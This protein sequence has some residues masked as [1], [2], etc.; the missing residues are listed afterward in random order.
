MSP[1][2]DYRVSPPD[3]RHA[4]RRRVTLEELRLRRR[5]IVSIG[6]RHGVNN[7]RVFGS[8]ARGDSE[9]GS[10]L[11]LLVD[12]T[13]GSSLWDLTDFALDVEEMLGVFTQVVTVSGLKARI[14]DHVLAE[15]VPL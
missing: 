8:V 6:D 1:T 15:A 9:D 12:V 7:V 3:E 4:P 11:D 14:R 5:E 2:Y 10:D 13:T